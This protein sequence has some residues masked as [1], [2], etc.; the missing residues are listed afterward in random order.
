MDVFEN[1]VLR[2]ACFYRKMC[3]IVHFLK[4][5]VGSHQK[6]AQKGQKRI[7]W[8]R[9]KKIMYNYVKLIRL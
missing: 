9:S 4:F 2:A 7:S 8:G 1:T 6:W 3:Y 5:N